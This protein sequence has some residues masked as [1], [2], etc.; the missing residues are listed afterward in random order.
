[1]RS[2]WALGGPAER[3]CDEAGDRTAIADLFAML[4]DG[5]PSVPGLYAHDPA[6]R[7]DAPT[8]Y[9]VT[10]TSFYGQGH[11]VQRVE[12]AWRVVASALV[13]QA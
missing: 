13:W 7:R 10:G 11:L 6:G 2:C 4:E 9:V 3:A 8:I 12:G 5:R 1:V